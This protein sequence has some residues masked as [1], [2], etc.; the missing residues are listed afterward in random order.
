MIP[1]FIV[2]GAGGRGAGYSSFLEQHPEEGKLVAICEPNE[3]RRTKLAAR[4]EIP[5][6]RQ[7][8]DW[9]EMADFA[10]FADA[11]MICTQDADHKAPAVALADKGYHLLLEKPMA[12]TA[13][14]SQA[15]YDAVTRA[16]VLLSVC[17]GLRYTPYNRKLKELLD[18]GLIGQIR[19]ID[20]M[21]PVGYWHM[22]HS[23]V[24]GNWRNTAESSPMLLAKSCHD[25]DFLNFLVPSRCERVASFGRLS[26]FNRD[27]QPAGAAD[28]CTDCPEAIESKCAYSA[29]KIYLRDFKN[30]L[31]DW[32]VD[33]VCTTPTP[34]AVRQALA[35]GPYG[36][37]VFA[38][39]ND[40]VD[41]QVVIM[42]FADGATATFTM[43]AF[44]QSARRETYVMGDQGT[45]RGTEWEFTHF[46]FLTNKKTTIEI[47][48]RLLDS[49]HDGGDGALMR[50]FIAAIRANDQNLISSGPEVSLESHLIVF[51]AEEARRTGAVVKV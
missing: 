6:S 13:A 36:R 45:L 49:G 8:R 32:P 7:Y 18:A 17:H 10:R 16:G 31:A 23:F 14:D 33:V 48:Q 12:P 24:R 38:C 9:R 3:E 43:S 28:R 1:T 47:D 34:E 37:C 46:D 35:E 20:L 44:N 39:D 21:E 26:Y 42:E 19:T 41:H 11:A 15:I 30:R 29:L 40:V 5:K 27:H 2:I 22:A 4:H 50:G 51:A 25:L